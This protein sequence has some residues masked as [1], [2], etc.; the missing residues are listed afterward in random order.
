MPLRLGD[1]TRD[2]AILRDGFASQ[3]KLRSFRAQPLVDKVW[4]YCEIPET[5]EVRSR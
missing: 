3:A 5:A 1:R 2:S 4:R